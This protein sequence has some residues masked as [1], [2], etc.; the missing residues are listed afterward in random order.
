MRRKK[1]FPGRIGSFLHGVE[2]E[3]LAVPDPLSTMFLALVGF[4]IGSLVVFIGTPK[5]IFNKSQDYCG[6]R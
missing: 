3:T 6:A 4:T 1:L 2:A 5:E